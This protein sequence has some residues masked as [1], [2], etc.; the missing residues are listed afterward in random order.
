MVAVDRSKESMTAVDR[1]IQIAKQND[2]ELIAVNILQL[3]IMS[4]YTPVVLNSAIE[5]GITETDEWF[6]GIRE[7]AAEK[8]INIKTKMIRIFG[9]PS[10]EIVDFAEKENADL[11]VM[12]TKGR[13]KLKKVLLGSTAFGVVM[14]APCTVMVVR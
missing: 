13:G 14:N 7:Q 1:S 11:I 2:A 4:P 5:K 6:D 9:S 3:P 8:G 10:S 12:G